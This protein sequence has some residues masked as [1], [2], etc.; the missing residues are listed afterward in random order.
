MFSTFGKIG[1]RLIGICCLWILCEGPFALRFVGR[2]P[3]CSQKHSHKLAFRVNG[4]WQAL[5]S[6]KSLA[7]RSSYHLSRR[8]ASNHNSWG[9]CL[10]LTLDI[11]TSRFRLS[12]EACVRSLST[13]QERERKSQGSLKFVLYLTWC[14]FISSSSSAVARKFVR[15]MPSTFK[16]FFS[17]KCC[18]TFSFYAL[19]CFCVALSTCFFCSCDSPSRINRANEIFIHPVHF[20]SLVHRRPPRT[21]NICSYSNF[22]SVNYS[23]SASTSH[24]QQQQKLFAL[25]IFIISDGIPATKYLC[26]GCVVLL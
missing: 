7:R 9:F 2:T 5:K 20:D 25:H 19:P 26:T 18:C 4:K 6:L 12:S 21:R 3:K 16:D 24:P 15:C 11:S 13:K 17:R 8:K 10:N 1:Q 23:V 14:R 22:P